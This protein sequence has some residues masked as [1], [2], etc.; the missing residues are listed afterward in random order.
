[1]LFGY[2][3]E[4]PE[5]SRVFIAELSRCIE[6]NSFPPFFASDQE[7]GSVQRFRGRAALPPPLSY[8]ED[9]QQEAARLNMDQG[10][11]AG[12]TRTRPREE[13][14]AL[15]LVRER[16]LL[17]VETGAE[18]AGREL[19]RLGVTLNLAPV[20]EVLTGKNGPFLK[21]RSYGPDSSFTAGAAAAFVRGMERAGVAA[22]VK[23]FP[24]NSSADPH[25]HRAVLDLSPEE[26]DRLIEPFR[27]I[28][29]REN[30]AAVMVSH[31][32]I[33]AWDSKPSSLSEEAIRRL[34]AL[35]FQGIVLADDF[36]MAAAGA[37]VE[38]CAVDALNAGVDMIMAWPADLRK[39]H[40]TI[41]TAL[42]RGELSEGRLREAAGRI[43]YQKLR[44]GLIR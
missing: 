2:N 26:L 38:K 7:G 18:T 34:R 44:Y 13:K 28:I 16:A 37:P 11:G 43:L 35:G 9:F 42:D 31:V 39:L 29:A 4:D 24:G 3:L 33:P 6:A 25:R 27:Y 23:H 30:P 8:W 22:A 5:K 40:R 12:R 10:T 20:A 14:E 41:L 17:L 36:A 1:M 19:R 21:D 32:I 15:D